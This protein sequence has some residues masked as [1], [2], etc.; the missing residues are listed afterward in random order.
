M[1]IASYMY[2]GGVSMPHRSIVAPSSIMDDKGKFDTECTV[3]LQA[4]LLPSNFTL[5]SPVFSCCLDC[6]SVIFFSGG[7]GGLL[8]TENKVG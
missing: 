7:G 4:L 5:H 8:K 6:L 1:E 3:R 2:A